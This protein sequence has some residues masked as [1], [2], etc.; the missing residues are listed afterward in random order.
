VAEVWSQDG[1]EMPTLIV[2]RAVAPTASASG[3]SFD[4]MRNYLL[5]LPGLSPEVAAQ[6]R[7]FQ[8]DASTLPLP[9]PAGQVNSA[10]A[11]VD[12]HDATVLTSRDGSMAAVVW[13]DHGVVTGVAGSLSSDEVLAVARGLR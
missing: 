9:I 11:D 6:L 12:G 1:G 10:T 2:A 8:P 7:S 4:T 13:V 3:V 5:S